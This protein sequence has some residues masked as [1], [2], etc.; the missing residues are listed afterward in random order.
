MTQGWLVSP[1]IEFDISAHRQQHV[2]IYPSDGKRGFS[3]LNSTLGEPRPLQG[4]DGGG[5]AKRRK[6]NRAR[7]RRKLSEASRLNYLSRGPVFL[8]LL[9]LIRSPPWKR[10][11]FHFVAQREGC[12]RGGE[13]RD[14]SRTAFN[15]WLFLRAGLS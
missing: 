13:A 3:Y 8:D 14:S 9:S 1:K 10:R 2:N 5:N 7:G 15:W 4:Q 12:S 6:R 11:K